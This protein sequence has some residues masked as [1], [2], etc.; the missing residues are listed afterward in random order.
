MNND[1]TKIKGVTQIRAANCVTSLKKC[2]TGKK[3]RPRKLNVFK[4]F[5]GISAMT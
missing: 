2:V 3:K 4:V 5:S 1:E